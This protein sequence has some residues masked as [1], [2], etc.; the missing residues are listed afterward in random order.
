MKYRCLAVVATLCAAGLAA[1]ERPPPS[2]TLPRVTQPITV[3]GDLSDPGW[4]EAA[5]IEVFYETNVGDNVPPPV[6]TVAWIGYDSRF[7]YMAFRCEDPEPNKIRAPFID[8][9]NVFS[10]QDF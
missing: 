1:D 3:D 6:K 10:E 8:R 5:R 4:Q 9:D 2:R 7:F